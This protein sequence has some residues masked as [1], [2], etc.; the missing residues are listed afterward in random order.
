VTG[1]GRPRGAGAGMRPG[2]YL[3]SLKPLAMRFGLERMERALE[4][5]GHPERDY[6]S[7]QVAGTN[8]KGSTCAM[9]AEALSRAGHRVGLYTSPHLVRF[10]ERIQVDGAPIAEAAL[11]E[12]VEEVRQA[13]PWHDG[14]DEADRLTYFEFATLAALAH[15]RRAGVGAA[16]LEVGLGGRFD[17]T[18]SVT[19][20]VTAVSL[21]GLDHVQLLG[22][23]LAA[24]A[25][26][27]A[28]IFKRGV[29]AVVAS[30]QPAEA[31][32]A[33]R[34]E[35]ERRGAPLHVAGPSWDGP[36]SLAGPHQRGNAALA[37][38]ALRLLDGAGVRVG[39][40]AIRAG[41]ASARWPG[42]LEEV[43]GV[44][45]DGAHNPDAAAALAIALPLL[46]PGRPVELVFGVLADK[47]HAGILRAIALAVRGLHL[48]RPDSPRGRAPGTYRDLA[49][50]LVAH[51]DV[52][53]GCAEAIACARDRA[54]D[55]GLACVAG[56]LY[57]VGEARRLLGGA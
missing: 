27:K 8:G 44:L 56:S 29:P 41:I 43:S 23:S 20:R 47:D 3:D 17:A 40:E 48:V 45:L 26:E 7:L 42:R 49:A 32:A 39:E 21:I 51:V 14:G 37:A 50:G 10:Q 38:A 15:F 24:I 25:R 11:A 2:D 5:L 28:G 22:D 12:A 9:A 31:M 18:T 6:P 16:V 35:A 33:L 34:D 52:H 36:V 54:R 53:S 13:C 1:A 46:H 19:P 55:G 57:L 4:A 30:A